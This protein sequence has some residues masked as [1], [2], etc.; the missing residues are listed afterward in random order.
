MKISIENF[1]AIKILTD[2]ELKPLTILSGVN[3]SGKS[4]FIQL[5]LLLKQTL[6]LDSTKN[7]LFLDGELYQ[8][9]AFK[10]ILSEKKIKNKLKIALE[11]SKK[12]D[13]ALDTGK[14]ITLFDPYKT[15]T[16][17]VEVIFDFKKAQVIITDFAVIYILPTGD[18]KEQ[19]VR[20]KTIPGKKDKYSIEANNSLF[21]DELWGQTPQITDIGYSSIF[22][23]Y[24]EITEI[25]VGAGIRK[26]QKSIKERSATKYFPKITGIK[27]L[28][29]QKF[30]SISYIGPL[31]ELPKDLYPKRSSKRHVGNQ[32]EFTAQVLENFAAEQIAF[33]KPL[34]SD[35]Q[36]RYEESE[37][38]LLKAV[39]IWMCDIFKI[40]YDIYAKSQGDAY[41]IFLKNEG[42]TVTTIKHVGFGISQ[43]LP[44]VVEGLLLPAAGTLILEQPE[45]HLH[46]KVQSLLFDFLYSL[47]KQGKNIII[48]TH[49][50]HF[51]TR[52]RRRIAE[53][54]DRDLLDAVN[55]TFIEVHEGE[56]YFE[57]I[58]LDEMGTVGYFPGDFIEQS[59]L[60]LKAIVQAQMHKRIS[61]S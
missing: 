33:L 1:K 54:S 25:E 13:L 12:E 49:S 32:G 28:L 55:L 21:G 36:I 19:F 59:S 9:A 40:G 16:I 26:G 47:V 50:D 11:F 20:F 43:V 35:D 61:E 39:K 29:N 7:P 6:E 17:K 60:E 57:E 44:I 53:S 58:E 10:D 42:G 30:Q 4:S 51:I 8:V 27:A 45:I 48:E 41:T 18:K 3:S 23:S 38:T 31:R 37:T 34:L 24:Y 22:P 15:F 52:M 5:L 56:I 46:P 14:R 2:Y